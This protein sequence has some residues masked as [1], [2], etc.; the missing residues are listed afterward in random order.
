MTFL[1]HKANE[2]MGTPQ[3]EPPPYSAIQN[4]KILFSFKKNENLLAGHLKF[5]GP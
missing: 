5:E 3:T 1:D 2:I 4:I